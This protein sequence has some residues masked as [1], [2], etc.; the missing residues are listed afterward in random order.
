MIPEGRIVL[1]DDV[2]QM[3]KNK[4]GPLTESWEVGGTALLNSRDGLLVKNYHITTDGRHIFF[5]AEDEDAW[6]EVIKDNNI[7]EV[8]LTFDQ[9][10]RLHISY[11]ANGI[12]KFYVYDSILGKQVIKEY[13]DIRNPRIS[14][15]DKRRDIGSGGSDIIFAYIKKENN[16]LC[17][18]VQRDRY[19]I[20]YATGLIFEEGDVLWRIG[21]GQNNAFMFYFLKG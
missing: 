15:D 9:Q 20:E 11:V 21:M 12:A 6:N 4:S 18:R 7:T 2:L 17:Y 14:L 5:K 19:E 13:P 8:D 10:M 1:S 16:E 3:P